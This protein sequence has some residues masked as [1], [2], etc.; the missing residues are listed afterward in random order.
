MAFIGATPRKI[1]PWASQSER[2]DSEA[3]NKYAAVSLAL[4]ANKVIDAMDLYGDEADSYIVM[5]RGLVDETTNSL[6]DDLEAAGFDAA[7]KLDEYRHECR[8]AGEEDATARYK[9]R[10]AAEAADR[11][12]KAEIKQSAMCAADTAGAM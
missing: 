7:E 2:A 11:N 8:W 6:S 4:D 9:A 5:A 10:V 1:D 3:F 12:R